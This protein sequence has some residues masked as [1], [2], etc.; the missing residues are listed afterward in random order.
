VGVIGVITTD[1]PSILEAAC[2]IGFITLFMALY[3]FITARFGLLASAVMLFTFILVEETPL[4]W[5]ASAWYFWHGLIGVAVVLA[6]AAYGFYTA[7]AGQRLF[8]KGFFG[9][10]STCANPPL[11]S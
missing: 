2:N 3:V 1:S 7:T 8:A 4:T 6:L 9:D 10:E 5:D 11:E